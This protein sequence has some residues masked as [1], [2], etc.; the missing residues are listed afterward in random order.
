MA[1]LDPLNGEAELPCALIVI[2]ARHDHPVR[3]LSVFLDPHR[4]VLGM[5]FL[6][7]R[8]DGLELVDRRARRGESRVAMR[9]RGRHHDRDVADN[10]VADA[11]MHRDAEWTVLPREAVGDLPHLLLGHLGV[12][13]V[14]EPQD[15]LPATLATDRAEE[16]DNP[17]ERVI[18]DERE[19]IVDRE[20]LLA[21]RDRLERARISARYRWNERQL[22]AIGERSVERC[23]F[24]IACDDDLPAFRDERVLMKDA[25]DRVADGRP[26]GHLEIEMAPSRRFA[27][28]REQ[29]NENAHEIKPSGGARIAR[30]WTPV[31]PLPWCSPS[32]SSSRTGSSSRRNTP[33]CGSARPSSMRSPSREVLA[34][35]SRRESWTGSTSTSRHPNLA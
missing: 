20:R 23:V 16:D 6:P 4:A 2:G 1:A 10:E 17:S 19:R 25:C 9:S 27:I 35:G 32:C 33:S 29:T 26:R 5:L 12:G 21:Y 34:R 30:A 15:A 8:H 28:R 18:A 24:A 31:P 11:V 22:V 14:L 3:H 7:D 13:L